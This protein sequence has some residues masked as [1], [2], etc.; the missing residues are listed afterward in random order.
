[1]NPEL[2]APMNNRFGPGTYRI[3]G[4]T[5][6][7]LELAAEASVARRSS[8]VCSSRPRVWLDVCATGPT[9]AQAT[10]WQAAL[11]SELEFVKDHAAMLMQ[12]EDLVVTERPATTR[13]RV[14]DLEQIKDISKNKLFLLMSFICSPAERLQGLR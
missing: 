12:A 4:T 3:H 13:A 7:R 5:A 14:V 6:V 8:S 9:K 10:I 11:G 1:M 2:K